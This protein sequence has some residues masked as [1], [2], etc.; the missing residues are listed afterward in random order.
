MNNQWMLNL[1]IE[2]M[3]RIWILMWYQGIF[4]QSS[5][6][7]QVCDINFTMEESDIPT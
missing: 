4:P 2:R 5:F 3:N 6:L 1:L 7:S